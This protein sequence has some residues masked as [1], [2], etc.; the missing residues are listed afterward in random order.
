[1]SIKYGDLL[2]LPLYCYQEPILTRTVM[3]LIC[4][5]E[6]AQINKISSRDFIYFIQFL[7]DI[8]TSVA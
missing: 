4:N 1:M 3:Y 2:C 5:I 6:V 7:I 8:S